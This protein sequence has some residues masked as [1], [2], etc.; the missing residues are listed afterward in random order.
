M[1]ERLSKPGGPAV[2]AADIL[3][4]VVLAEV[5]GEVGLE[6]FESL[7]DR[8]AEDVADYV[9][10]IEAAGQAGDD[11]AV[12]AAAHTLRGAAAVFG[13]TQLAAC[14]G[15][16]EAACAGGER[17]RALEI[18]APLPAMAASALAAFGAFVVSRRSNADQS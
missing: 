18:A 6:T 11:D 3:D 4:R 7:I 2:A 13:A 5:V 17:A 16:I 10:R 14:A 12:R 9:T 1:H 8:L 15:D